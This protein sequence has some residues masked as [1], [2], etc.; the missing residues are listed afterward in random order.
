[1]S[2][3]SLVELSLPASETLP[4]AAADGAR[5]D[6]MLQLPPGHVSQ[7][8]YWLPALGVP[9]KHYLPLAQSL[10]E[11]GIAVAIHEWRGIGS[12]NRR[13]G[14]REDWGYRELLQADLPAGL[15][16][17]RTRLPYA[18]FRLG[19][20]SLGAQM[21]SLYAALHPQEVAGLVVVA[22]GSPYWRQFRYG[23]F[24]RLG[25]VAAPW[26]ARAVG[27]LPGRRL[28]FG[29]NEAR[30]LIDDWARSGRTGQYTAQGMDEDLEQRLCELELPLL[31]LRLQDDWL[32]PQASLAWLLGKMPRSCSVQQVMTAADLNGVHADHFRWMKTPW[33][34]AERIADWL[35]AGSVHTGP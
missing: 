29:G 15:A 9:A 32:A 20:H 33:P 30:R 22:S 6:V 25:Y 34:I 18:G 19:G 31:A 35:E 27:Y 21:A 26:L 23:R 10:A 28:G 16:A 3:A 4:A 17:V 7:V 12:S 13:A 8:L 14:R 24:I 2:A 5:A 1:M 11:R